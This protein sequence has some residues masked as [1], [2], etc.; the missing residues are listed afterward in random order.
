MSRK[1]YK[2]IS[3]KYLVIPI[4]M[5]TIIFSLITYH[6]INLIEKYFCSEMQS[7]TEK[8]AKGYS[9]SVEK[10]LDANLLIDEMLGE[11][12]FVSSQIAA[13]M[14]D[15][16][17]DKINQLAALLAVD[18]IHIYDSSGIIINSTNKEYL[19]WRAESGHPVYNFMESSDL[20]LV[21]DIRPDSESGI[22]YK[23]AYFKKLDDSFVQVGIK[24][25]NIVGLLSEFSLEHLLAE[26]REIT[27]V[28]RIAYLDPDFKIRTTTSEFRNNN[29]FFGPEIQKELS[30]NN[31]YSDL[32]TIEGENYY[33]TIFEI[34]HEKHPDHDFGYL[35]IIYPFE[36]TQNTINT[37]K[38]I[39]L[40]IIVLV[41]II[42][43]YTFFLSY[44]K[45]KRLVKMSYYDRLTDLP[46][47]EYLYDVLQNEL[48]NRKNALFLI[49]CNNFT[50]INLSLGYKYGDQL[51]KEFSNQLKNL[52]DE[53][54]KLFRFDA[55]RFILLYQNYNDDQ[56]LYNE[57]EA[58]NKELKKI[59]A[60]SKFDNQYL[61]TSI[62]VEKEINQYQDTEVIINNLNIALDYGKKS[63]S[64]YLFFNQEMKEQIKRKDNLESELRESIRLENDK[65]YLE[66]Q[67]IYDL[68]KNKVVAFEALARMQSSQYDRVA[69]DEFIQIAEEKHL[70]ISLSRLILKKAA[71]FSADLEKDG[72]GEVK[73]SVNMSGLDIIQEDFTKKIIE[74]I[75]NAGIKAENIKIEITE[76]V[77][78]NNF[79][80]I[81]SKLAKLKEAGITTA[82]D[83]FGT[84]YSSFSRLTELNIDLIKIDKYFINKITKGTE[85][86]IVAAAIIDLSHSLGLTVV[87]EGVETESQ[88][89]YLIEKNCDYIQ[90]YLFS[91]PLPEEDV[92]KL[93]KSED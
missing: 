35:S 80:I 82:L 2:V 61:S 27:D 46:N 29:Y 93:L 53:K 86:N 13:L 51:I 15:D 23:Y 57:V 30:K 21:E 38:K 45:N 47:K 4:I 71:K 76:S 24:A 33:N 59:F 26:I 28:K 54:R 88:R 39:L 37:F 49:N 52:E 73:I 64:P 44:R 31:N 62:A 34:T 68:N 70:I 75:N 66:Y 7:K 79:E 11:K 78:L 6:S 72:F 60:K 92:F 10:G 89:D 9:Y 65:I 67:P 5:T 1:N 32:I 58:I 17:Q 8:I 36:E 18:A 83:D 48:D 91:K 14:S 22:N 25:E 63:G 19:G 3:L 69:P 55:E 43:I 40:A 85:N 41:Y 20:G 50:L 77:L 74:I 42:L 87:A 81:N 84:G 90:G 16:Y 56:D 12:L